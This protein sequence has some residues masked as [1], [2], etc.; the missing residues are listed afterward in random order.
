MY[1]NT[2]SVLTTF[3]LSN[4]SRVTVSTEAGRLG[5]TARGV[6]TE[7]ALAVTLTAGS[8]ASAGALSA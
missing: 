1:F 2:S 8:V 6:A 5:S 4:C 7:L 3:Q